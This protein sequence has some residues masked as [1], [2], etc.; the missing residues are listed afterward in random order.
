MLRLVVA[1]R[2]AWRLADLGIVR[3][4]IEESFK[5]QRSCEPRTPRGDWKDSSSSTRRLRD[6]SSSSKTLHDAASDP[7]SGPQCAPVARQ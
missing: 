3:E 7:R 6:S 1:R 2:L 4:R 5:R